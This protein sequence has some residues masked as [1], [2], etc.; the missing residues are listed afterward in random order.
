[1]SGGSTPIRHRGYWEDIGTIRSFYEANLDLC[2][3][4]PRFN[5][6]DATSPIFTHARY[7]PATKIIK[8]RVERSII[9]DGCIINDADIE[10][11]LL[12]VRSRIEAGAA[13]RDSLADG[14][15]LLRD[16]RSDLSPRRAADGDR[17]RRLDRADDRGQERPHRG[18]RSHHARREARRIRRTQ[19]LRARRDRH[20]PQE[21]RHARAGPSSERSAPSHRS[22]APRVPLPHTRTI[23]A[24]DPSADR[25]ACLPLPGRPRRPEPA[26]GFWRG[27]DA[28]LPPEVGAMGDPP[29]HR[30]R[31]EAGELRG[32]R[33]HPGHPGHRGHAGREHRLRGIHQAGRQGSGPAADH[34][35]LQWRTGLVVYVAAHGRARP[36]A[37]RRHRRGPDAAPSVPCRG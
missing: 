18:R 5:F 26:Q 17:A 4:L 24:Y 20:H 22:P 25:G 32:H 16:P 6:Y 3:P 1:M 27:E 9:S 30:D 34:L 35:R 28:G 29:Q 11:S 36:P 33:R 21:R 15:R 19:L 13:L 37:R 2:E 8:S 12:G 10:H 7:L 31:R 14:P 23:H